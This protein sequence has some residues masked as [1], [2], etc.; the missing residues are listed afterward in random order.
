MPENEKKQGGCHTKK[1]KG[2]FFNPFQGKVWIVTARAIGRVANIASQ[3]QVEE[4]WMFRKETEYPRKQEVGSFDTAL[5][6][7]TPIPAA[8]V[9]SK[10]CDIIAED[11]F[12][13]ASQLRLVSSIS[14]QC[15]TRTQRAIFVDFRTEIGRSQNSHFLFLSIVRRP[16][17][18]QS[19][20]VFFI[21]AC[22]AGL[23]SSELL[24]C[25]QGEDT[26]IPTCSRKSLLAWQS[27]CAD[28]CPKRE[29]S[30]PCPKTKRSR[31]DAILKREKG[32]FSTL[33]KAKCEV[34]QPGQSG[35]LRTSPPRNK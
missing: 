32:H 19:D 10:A 27:S 7:M 13:V 8:F 20:L 4:P 23:S 16:H 35:V 28:T 31:E 25:V 9:C 29:V 17:I 14:R 3:K 18:T 6:Q 5:W 11:T 24:S 30:T 33:S 1:R 2:A 21:L 34:L 26:S 22:L 15:M 12:S